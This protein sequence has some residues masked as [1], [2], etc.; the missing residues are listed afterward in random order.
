MESRRIIVLDDHPIVRQAVCDYIKSQFSTTEILEL[1]ESTDLFKHLRK[2]KPT[3]L[4]LDLNLKEGS[5]IELMP[6]IRNLY[7]QLKM[8]VFSALPKNIYH[9]ALFKYDIYDY[10]EKNI[11]FENVKIILSDFIYNRQKIRTQTVKVDSPFVKLTTKEFE[12][13]S[14]LLHGVSLKDI[15]EKLN[16]HGNTVSTY[17]T[18]IFEKT[19]TKN[20]MDLI[21][22]CNLWGIQ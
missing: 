13:L 16:L 18:R 5:A 7:P 22:L 15:G 14:Y 21:D 4:V 8:L 17:K 19:N 2:F 1:G 12:V 6:V 11:D 10:V 20:V 9:A 3:H